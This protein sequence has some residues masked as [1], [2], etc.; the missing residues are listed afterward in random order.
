MNTHWDH[1]KELKIVKGTQKYVGIYISLK[2]IETQWDNILILEPLGPLANTE[3]GLYFD[4]LNA[5]LLA[6][7]RCTKHIL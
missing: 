2:H 1:A 4:S 6:F 3:L 7:S 5:M